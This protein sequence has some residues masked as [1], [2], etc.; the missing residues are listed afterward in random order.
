VGPPDGGVG[1]EADVGEERLDV[2]RHDM[3]EIKE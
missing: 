2:E 1:G 3:K